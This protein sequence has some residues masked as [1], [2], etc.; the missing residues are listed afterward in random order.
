MM[1]T[2]EIIMAVYVVA[3]IA[4]IWKATRSKNFATGQRPK[5]QSHGEFLTMA[6][7]YKKAADRNDNYREQVKS[8]S[9][10]LAEVRAAYRKTKT[11]YHDIANHC[12]QVE[13]RILNLLGD[14]E[15][16]NKVKALQA[17]SLEEY[18]KEN[19]K[20][21]HVI[22]NRDTLI[23]NLN[24]DLNFFKKVRDAQAQ[25]IKEYGDKYGYS[26]EARKPIDQTIHF[27]LSSELKEA[28]AEVK[29]LFKTA[30]E[31]RET[32]SVEDFHKPLFE[33]GEIDEFIDDDPKEAPPRPK[34]KPND[35][36]SCTG[37]GESDN[38]YGDCQIC[39]GT[40]QANPLKTNRGYAE[41]LPQTNEGPDTCDPYN[42]ENIDGRV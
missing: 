40:G 18:K 27:E 32:E 26:E 34:K 14:L 19:L 10:E 12:V 29:E 17:K 33:T 15:T 2:I 16:A 9:F 39:C 35:C 22:A 37:T 11:D 8:L 1:T 36:E 23:D 25:T 13:K 30:D 20:Q 38:G 24:G 41:D 28:F 4:L 5:R 31:T 21:R 6:E 3:I 7:L 42:N